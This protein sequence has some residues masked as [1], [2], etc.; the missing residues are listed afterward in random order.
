M[1]LLTVLTVVLILALVA[2]LVAG[3][4]TISNT[5]H[6]IG[7]DRVSYMGDRMHDRQSGLAKVRWGLRAIE[8][9]T[10]VIGPGVAELNR[11]LTTTG[12]GLTEVEADLDDLLEAVERQG[13]GR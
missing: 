11:L 3:L 10:A 6:D 9:H 4:V 1:I 12:E 13:A 7:G 8:R 5:L 2:V